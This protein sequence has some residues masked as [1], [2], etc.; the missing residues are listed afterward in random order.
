MR[1]VLDRRGLLSQVGS[2]RCYTSG[3]VWT[4]IPNLREPKLHAEYTHDGC[5]RAA[6]FNSWWTAGSRTSRS[7]SFS[8]RPTAG[9]VSPRRRGGSHSLTAVPTGGVQ[10][11]NQKTTPCTVAKGKSLSGTT[12]DFSS[13]MND[14]T[15]PYGDVRPVKDK[16]AKPQLNELR[17]NRTPQERAALEDFRARGR[18]QIAPRIKVREGDGTQVGNDHPERVLGF[19]LLSQAFGTADLD[20][21][22]G[23][24]EQLVRASIKEG[25][26]DENAVN[27]MASVIKSV[28]PR[29]ELEA[30]LA[31]QMAAVHVAAMRLANRLANAETIQAA[32]QRRARVQ[33]TYTDLCDADGGAQ[34]LSNGRRAESN[35]ATCVCE[36][37]RSGDCGQCDAGARQDGSERICFHT[38]CPSSAC[39]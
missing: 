1:P 32:G 30:M 18:D 38:P 9:P 24:I 13:V 3:R 28:K 16:K 14:S 35:G 23:L 2:L 39:D 8:F 25:E 6:T 5:I 37:R 7:I 4:P 33:Q 21:T 19:V 12:T 34:A 17:Q 22:S 27:F 36:R 31:A 10:Y 29:D 26:Y 11:K 15:A 20:F